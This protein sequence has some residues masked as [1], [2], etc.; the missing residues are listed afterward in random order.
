MF[1]TVIFYAAR[2]L[3]IGCGNGAN[4]RAV[5]PD[6]WDGSPIEEAVGVDPRGGNYHTTSKKFFASNTEVV[7]LIGVVVV[8]VVVV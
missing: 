3:E 6:E 2:Y 8:V 7:I 1:V 4:F 5:G